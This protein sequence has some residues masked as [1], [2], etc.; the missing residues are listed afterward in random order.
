MGR[1]GVEFPGPTRPKGTTW[2]CLECLRLSSVSGFTCAV[3]VTTTLSLSAT[4][5]DI[6]YS[7]A[8]TRPI[9]NLWLSP[10]GA[11]LKHG[12]IF[13]LDD[14]MV[15]QTVE[16]EHD[17]EYMLEVELPGCAAAAAVDRKR[18]SRSYFWIS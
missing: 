13:Y 1:A 6:Q 11:V 15:S 7:S 16:D 14:V 18:R 8:G 3:S 17:A 5:H 4:R 9:S 10:V 2:L 12:G